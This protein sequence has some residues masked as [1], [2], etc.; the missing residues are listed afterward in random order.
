MVLTR[1][2]DFPIHQTPEPIAYAGSDRN[3]YDRYFF[4]GYTPD[5]SVYFAVGFGI[6]PHLNIMD[7]SFSVIYDGVQHNV[8]ASRIMGMER[9][10]L[11][12]GPISI[13][14]VEPLHSLRVTVDD[15]TSGIK[16]E[17]LFTARNRAVEEPRFTYRQGPRMLLDYTRLTQMGTYEGSIQIGGK[18]IAIT[19]EQVMGTRDR[20]W[21]IR[22]IGARDP[23]PLAP[24]QLP[25]F[26]WLW[27][28]VNYDDGF[29][30]FH[31]NDDA[32]GNSWNTRGVFGGLGDVEAEE[33]ALVNS[34][35]V[36]KPGTR[37]AS[38][39]SIAMLL[40]KDDE[41]ELTLTPKFNFYMHGIGY[42]HPEWA[43][44]AHHGELETAYDSFKTAD[45][46]DGDVANLHIQAFCEVQLEGTRGVKTGRGILEQLVMGPHAPSGLTGLTDMAS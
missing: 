34:Q 42:G 46:D 40:G 29:S 23:Q 2:D 36:F 24:A 11:Q 33:T 30:L 3:F 26:Y 32:M 38:S 45:V 41:L 16:A 6:Y 21:G 20:S 22:P 1:A 5:G 44:G 10:D 12:V 8:R 7:G 19:P 28:P 25:Q 17:L 35:M 13:E 39:A 43:H 27:A 15:K 31:T 4:N 9:T 18:T 14:I 37:H